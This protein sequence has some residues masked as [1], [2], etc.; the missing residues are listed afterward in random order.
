MIHESV[1]DKRQ[2]WPGL[3][4]MKKIFP[5]ALSVVYL[6]ILCRIDFHQQGEE[7]RR[8]GGIFDHRQRSQMEI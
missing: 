7:E 4:L 3:N 1:S 8:C 5:N 2:R 6:A